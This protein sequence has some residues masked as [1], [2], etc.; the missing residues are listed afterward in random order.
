[1]QR[2]LYFLNYPI[3]TVRGPYSLNGKSSNYKNL[4][5]IIARPEEGIR[6]FIGCV[7]KERILGVSDVSWILRSIARA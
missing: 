2:S 6:V 4:P 7:M 1:M 3:Q 5:E